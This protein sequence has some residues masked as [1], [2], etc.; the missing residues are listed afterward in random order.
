MGVICSLGKSIPDFW[1]A[2]TRGQPGIRPIEVADSSTLK[3][4][5]GAEVPEYDPRRYFDLQTSESIDRFA[6]FALIAS[7][8]AVEDAGVQWS[9]ELR[10]TAAV[11]TGSCAGGQSAV[12]KGFFDLY[13]RGRPRVHPLTIPKTMA[14]AGASHIAIEFGITGPAF[15]ISTA[16]SSSAHAISLAYTM[17]ASGAAS[18]AIAGGSEAPFSL[19]MLKAWEALRVISPTTCRPFSIDRNGMILGEAGAMIVLETMASAL[20]RGAR[21][22]SELAGFGMSSDACHITHPSSDGAASAMQRALQSA[23]IQPERIGYINAHGTGTEINDSTETAAI[24]KVFGTHAEK[25]ALSS[26][27]SMH[28][29]TLG[30]AGALEAI[31]S[32][33]ALGKGVLPPTANFTQPD[34]HCCLDVVPNVA[35]PAEVEYCLSNSFAF[36][37]LNASLVFR[38]AE[39]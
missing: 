19:G 20:A 38:R 2:L 32:V 22:H 29:H 26:T 25:L 6:Q 11:I 23:G 34:P 15:T 13:R 37:G 9:P 3:C 33:L 24:R 16:C 36:G 12:D 30:A 35:R 8:Q 4:Q 28:G 14:N 18:M 7:R 39:Q 21:I 17:V 31:A 1:E 27:K 10:S 5:N